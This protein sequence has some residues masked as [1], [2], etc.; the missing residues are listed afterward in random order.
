MPADALDPL[1]ETAAP[2]IGALWYTRCPVPTA[3]SLAIDLGW[4]D[5]EFADDGITVSSLRAS[6]DKAVRESHFD[7]NQ[8]DSFRQGGNIPP[9]WTRSHGGDIALVAISWVDEYQAL[10]AMPGSGIDSVKDLRGRRLGMPRRVNDQID[11]WRAICLR[12]YLSALSLEGMDGGDVELIDLPVDESYIGAGSVSRRGT[13][14]SGAHRARRQQAD[15]FALIRGE[16]DAIYTA[17]A[18]GAQLAAFL[19][20]HDVVELGRHPDPRI[21]CNNQ[22]PTILT[23]S[24]RLARERPDIVARYIERLA[25]AAAWAESHRSET[26]RIVANDVGAPEEWVDAAYGDDFTSRLGLDLSEAG[27]TAVD[28]QKDFLLRHGFIERDF[29]IGEWIEPGPLDIAR[30]TA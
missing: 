2:G 6:D 23:V 16:V 28:S 1:T 4:L 26:V 19:G 8:T 20:A 12:A 27:I 7:H 5:D 9:I 10:I 24:G 25:A 15:A 30:R 14:W 13:L 11:F 29:D 18:P 22:T 17:G 3:S 21:R